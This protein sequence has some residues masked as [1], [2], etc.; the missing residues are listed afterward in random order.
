MIKHIRTFFFPHQILYT[1]SLSK[2]LIVARLD[3]VLNRKWTLLD[4]NNLLGEFKNKD[5]FEIWMK[6]AAYGTGL[7]GKSKLVAEILE[8][9]N[10]Q[11]EVKLKAKPNIGL[12]IWF[13]VFVAFSI[14]YLCDAI[15]TGSIKFI[16]LSCL[17]LI[18]GPLLCVG[19]SNVQ[20]AALKDNYIK[21]IDK[22]LRGV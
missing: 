12:Y 15:N 9:Q 2:E 6:S 5:T 21:Y 19:I 1:F 10:G 3:E 16:L 18:G 17:M 13:F 20:I 11:T 22:N 4:N 14:V 8:S 7:I